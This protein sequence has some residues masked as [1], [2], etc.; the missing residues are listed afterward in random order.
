MYQ[1]DSKR[2][3]VKLQINRDDLHNNTEV[4]FNLNFK[5][6]PK[7]ELMSSSQQVYMIR[8]S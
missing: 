2:V 6:A 8:Y 5:N 4:V 7:S 1:T 3:T